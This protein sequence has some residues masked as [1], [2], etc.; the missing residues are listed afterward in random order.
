MSAVSAAFLLGSLLIFS[1][2]F[3]TARV[4]HMLEYNMFTCRCWTHF[5]CFLWAAFSCIIYYAGQQVS[6]TQNL[7]N[8]FSFRVNEVTGLHSLKRAQNRD[9]TVCGVCLWCNCLLITV[10]QDNNKSMTWPQSVSPLYCSLLTELLCPAPTESH[11][12]DRQDSTRR[13][14]CD[15]A[16]RRGPEGRAAQAWSW[17]GTGCGWVVTFSSDV[18]SAWTHGCT[19]TQM[20]HVAATR[21]TYT[22][23]FTSGFDVLVN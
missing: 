4:I 2:L 12:E 11:Q 6:V 14:G 9:T 15:R 3:Q 10:P 8:S 17:R 20:W 22:A 16:D 1:L 23:E 7:T 21:C 5:S 19:P 18:L 13:A